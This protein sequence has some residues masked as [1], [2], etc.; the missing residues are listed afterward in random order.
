ML[1]VSL[2]AT[3]AQDTGMLSL[4]LA[5]ISVRSAKYP[6]KKQNLLVMV[7]AFKE[8]RNSVTPGLGSLG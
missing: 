7:S 8:L 5:F 6:V 2:T 3:T 1:P 4:A